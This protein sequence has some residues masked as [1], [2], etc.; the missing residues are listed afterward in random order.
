MSD[1]PYPQLRSRINSIPH[2][3]GVLWVWCLI[4]GA[5]A[6]GQNQDQAPPN[7][8]MISLNFPENVELKVLVEYVSQRLGVNI[9]YD[10]QIGNR[11][12]TIKAPSQIPESSLLD[13]LNSALQMKGLAMVDDKQPGWKRIV[14]AG[15]LI[16]IARSPE[17]TQR[18]AE[19]GRL[20]AA[21]AVTR[22]FE[23]E[24][25][26]ASRIDQLVKPFLTQPG[27][28]SLV[29]PGSRLLVVTDYASN[30]DR[31]EGLVRLA[32]QPVEAIE[33]RFIPAQ[34]QEA[35]QLAQQA[36]KLIR[37]KLTAQH[38]AAGGKGAQPAQGLDVTHDE[39][40]NQVVVVGT[41]DRIEDAVKV[42]R[43]LDVSLDMQT[44]MYQFQVASPQRIDQLT[45]DLIGPLM[46]KRLYRSAVDEQGGMLVVA[47]T[48]QIHQKILSLKK[49]LD[50]VLPESQSPIR[51]YK[52][53]NAVA[54]DVLETIRVLEGN[55]GLFGG[56]GGVDAQTGLPPL[57]TSSQPLT[58]R[59]ETP[60][61]AAA[62][63]PLR[64][65]V[66]AVSTDR[67]TI[68]AD[69]NTNTLIVVAKPQDQKI[70]EKLI[71]ELDKRRPQV[72]VEVT[73]V[74]LDTSGGYSVGV[75]ISNE[76]TA[77][78]G[79]VLNFSSFGLSDV[80]ASTGALTISPG[81]GFNGALI[82]PSIADIVIRA[83]TT[84]IRTRV[85]SS[86]RIL[87]NDNATGTL[88]SIDEEPFTSVNASDTV[89]TTSFGGFVEA[90]TTISV[91]PHISQSDHLSLEYSVS[92]NSFSGGGADGI[93][94]PRQTNS[95][96]SEVTVPDGH[97]VIVGGLRRT[98]NTKTIRAV[99]LLGEIPILKHLFSNESLDDSELTLFVFIRPVILRDD[100]FAD[101]KYVS[102]RPLIA[103]D[104]PSNY[105]TSEPLIIR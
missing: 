95:I 79:R 56:E 28:N 12:I 63:Q 57:R 89:S 48:H 97:T 46:E 5:V 69:T 49:D 58:P 83:L 25:A 32:D 21:Q 73:I 78:E 29:V 33:I 45:K 51:F 19:S 18:L 74:A 43:S 85:V 66:E 20:G 99:P 2:G 70:Y 1:D 9:L 87:V 61:A 94:P 27:G 96:E 53:M 42:I 31:V 92:L 8:G 37:A 101:L 41:R 54:A 13:L 3:L 75:E 24:H 80:D 55:E 26:D 100:K 84:D 39:R 35:S 50:V 86:P 105:P 90:G 98:S 59:D 68:T 71:R 23:I 76:H 14:Q 15:N 67:A 30:M 82:S 72:L 102:E 17:E 88:D 40:T 11:R 93:P 81:L 38:R 6:F 65:V 7:A 77:G 36:S 16:A 91:T 103:A 64:P 62:G 22:V 60:Q 104:M 34:H 4:G 10:E 44:R 47:T 52:L